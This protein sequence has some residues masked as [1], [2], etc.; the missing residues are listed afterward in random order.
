MPL[1]QVTPSSLD[2]T[3]TSLYAERKSRVGTR[4]V[5]LVEALAEKGLLRQARKLLACKDGRRSE[6]GYEASFGYC[7]CGL[8]YCPACAHRDQKAKVKFWLPRI[9][10]VLE[11]GGRCGAITLTLPGEGASVPGQAEVLRRALKRI[12]V[13]RRWRGKAGWAATLGLICALEV[14]DDVTRRPNPHLHLMVFGPSKAVDDF[15]KWLITF[16]LEL[17]PAASPRGQYCDIPQTSTDQCRRRLVYIFKRT[18]LNP[19]WSRECLEEVLGVFPSRTKHINAWGK[20]A[21]KPRIRQLVEHRPPQELRV[22]L[23]V[24]SIA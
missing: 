17:H 10:Q 1:D 2:Q 24:S 16:W 19:A 13:H 23:E 22:R 11:A 7:R 6:F 12:Q 18:R 15:S 20:L 14:S 5:N 8:W 3:C 21:R 4:W 9:L